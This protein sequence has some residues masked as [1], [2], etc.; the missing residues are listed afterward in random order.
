MED[1]IYIP[2]N[3]VESSEPQLCV[4]CQYFKAEG[5][6]FGRCRIR[7][8]TYDGFP[9]VVNTEWCGEWKMAFTKK[10]LP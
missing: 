5:P 3:P 9:M 6:N 10:E 4:N 7:A 8:K 2:P 1:M